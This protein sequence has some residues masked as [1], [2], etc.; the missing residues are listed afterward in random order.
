MAIRGCLSQQ[1]ERT[2][3]EVRRYGSWMV[4]KCNNDCAVD[5][6]LDLSSVMCLVIELAVSV[7]L[8]ISSKYQGDARPSLRA[9]PKSLTF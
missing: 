8:S 1:G 3:I 5:M 4:G 9:T 2:R 7:S 6:S